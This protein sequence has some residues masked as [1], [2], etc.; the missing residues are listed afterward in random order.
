MQ[1]KPVVALLSTGNE[2]RDLHDDKSAL[3]DAEAWSGVWDT[4]RPSLQTAL[5]G[6][7]YDVVD[8]GIVPDEWVSVDDF[9]SV[10]AHNI[11]A[12]LVIA[13]NSK[14]R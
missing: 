1:R 6:L 12:S 5:I 7:G 2:L 10:T 9:S 13:R 4:N 14:L 8:F 3:E 11:A